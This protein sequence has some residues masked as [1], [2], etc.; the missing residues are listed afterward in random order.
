MGVQN[1]NA[2]IQKLKK[3]F[4]IE[5]PASNS[6]NAPAKKSSIEEH[7]IKP[8]A[9]GKGWVKAKALFDSAP[10]L[11]E[12]LT[13]DTIPT[14]DGS[15]W[16]KPAPAEVKAVKYYTTSSGCASI[17]TTLR[18]NK[19]PSSEAAKMAKELDNAFDDD[20]MAIVK[21]DVKVYRGENVPQPKIDEWIASIENDLPTKYAKAG[22]ISTRTTT[23]GYAANSNVQ[24]EIVIPKG[25]RALYVDPISAHQGE[26]EVLLPHGSNFH[27]LAVEKVGI[28]R[29]KVQVV[30]Q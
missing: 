6:V 23:F 4:G 27:I 14:A 8:K 25:F 15:A 9:P 7:L 3:D 1:T 24:Y 16:Q 17:N 28:G 11:K 26:N 2:Y 18:T 29:Y 22:I 20:E 12:H 30:L 13:T 5:A 21:K 19:A 10:P